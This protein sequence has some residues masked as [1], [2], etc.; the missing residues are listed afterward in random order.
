MHGALMGE[1]G[2]TAGWARLNLIPTQINGAVI[3]SEKPGCLARHRNDLSPVLRRKKLQ[4]RHRH[5]RS[6]EA[7]REGLISTVS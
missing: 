7:E 2:A 4:A 1:I 5:I 6:V 3:P